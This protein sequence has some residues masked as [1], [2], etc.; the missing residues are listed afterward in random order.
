M[1]WVCFGYVLGMVRS[2][3]RRGTGLLTDGSDQVMDQQVRRDREGDGTT[4]TVLM[5]FHALLPKS[6]KTRGSIGGEWTRRL[7]A[8]LH[9]SLLAL[10]LRLIWWPYL[11][12]LA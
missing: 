5:I 12:Q 1:F 9:R 11:G 3:V 8:E 4:V 2:C 7:V 10:I 6:L